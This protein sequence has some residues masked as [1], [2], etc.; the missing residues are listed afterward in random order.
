MFS[1]VTLQVYGFLA[2]ILALATVAALRG[3]TSDI[4]QYKREKLNKG[5]G[6]RDPHIGTEELQSLPS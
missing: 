2:F 5:S 3:I 6:P 4:I 1:Q